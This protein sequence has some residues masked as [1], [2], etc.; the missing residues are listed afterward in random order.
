MA[1]ALLKDAV[2]IVDG[3]G[4]HESNIV[5]ESLKFARPVLRRAAGFHSD[6]AARTV[7][8]DAVIIVKK[9]MSAV[10]NIST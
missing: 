3:F 8:K 1:R 5:A 10:P 9:G 6:Q 7:L 2:S 4:V